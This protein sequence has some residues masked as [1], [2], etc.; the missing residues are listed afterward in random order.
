MCTGLEPDATFVVDGKVDG[1]SGKFPPRTS[2]PGGSSKHGG[3]QATFEIVVDRLAPA[4]LVRHNAMTIQVDATQPVGAF[5]SPT[6][7][8]APTS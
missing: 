1:A 2:G 8:T 7:I 5:N 6:P 3:E 4:L